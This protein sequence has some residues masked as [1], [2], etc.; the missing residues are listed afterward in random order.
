MSRRARR[1]GRPPVRPASELQE[2]KALLQDAI[3][4]LIA[5]RAANPGARILQYGRSFNSTDND[6]LRRDLISIDQRLEGLD[7]DVYYIDQEQERRRDRDI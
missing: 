2:R 5:H 7:I 6:I 3:A 4:Q 1:T